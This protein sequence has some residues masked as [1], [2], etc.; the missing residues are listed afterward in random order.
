M[1]DLTISMISSFDT[2]KDTNEKQLPE[3]FYHGFAFEG[4]EVLVGLGRS[5]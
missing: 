2:G 1:N 3:R 5:I 4:K